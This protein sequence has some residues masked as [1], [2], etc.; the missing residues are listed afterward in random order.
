MQIVV[1]SI[2]TQPCSKQCI[3]Y[4]KY[5][6]I[7]VHK[8]FL[9]LKICSQCKFF[10]NFPTST[11]NFQSSSFVTRCKERG[12]NFMGWSFSLL[13]IYKVSYTVDWIDKFSFKMRQK[14]YKENWYDFITHQ[15]MLLK[16]FSSWILREKSS[17]KF[18]IFNLILIKFKNNVSFHLKISILM[19]DNFIVLTRISNQY[20]S[21][22]KSLYPNYQTVSL[23]DKW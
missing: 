3:K 14:L 20:Q 4:Q 6:L 19:T 9:K 7:F 21:I 22:Q 8:L 16:T 5:N 17:G 10:E 1:F 2:N 11:I 15:S 13:F 12:E 23:C 18:V